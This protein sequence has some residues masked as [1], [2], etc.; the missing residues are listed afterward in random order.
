MTPFERTIMD[1]VCD[2]HIKNCGMLFIKSRQDFY[3]RWTY[4]DFTPTFESTIN[5][6]LSPTEKQLLLHM[7]KY[8]EPIDKIAAKYGYEVNMVLVTINA[9]FNR[10]ASVYT[11]KQFYIG[12]DE[13][14]RIMDNCRTNIANALIDN[15]KN[16]V[17]LSEI[18]LSRKACRCIARYLKGD[19]TKITANYAIHHISKLL[20]VPS[21]GK[22]TAK[23]IVNVFKGNGINCERW[24]KEIDDG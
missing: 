20:K 15:N 7:Y 12:S 2:R 6:T 16:Q 10:L 23:H 24:E 17:L 21:V 1:E 14:N 5:S 19:P 4:D 22:D 18:G 9:I 8:H 13:F 3:K 11:F